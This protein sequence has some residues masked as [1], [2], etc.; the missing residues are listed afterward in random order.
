MKQLYFD[1]DIKYLFNGSKSFEL[2]QKVEGE[3]YREH[4]N[5]ITKKIIVNHKGY[6]IKLHGPVGWREIFKNLIQIKIPVIG[7]TRELKALKHLA[8]HGVN[9]LS[10]I[11][12]FKRGIIP[13]YSQSFL[14]TKE[15]KK[16]ISLEDFFMEGLHKKLLFKHKRF[17]LEKI[18]ETLRKIH[19]SGMN[20]RDLYLCHLHIEKDCNFNDLKIFVI[21]LHRAQI[22]KNVPE[23]WLVKDLGGFLHST[24]GFGLTER[25]Y[26]RFFKTYFNCSLE[27][28]SSKHIL[29]RI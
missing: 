27:S 6:F 9:T 4:A 5:R 13:A 24:M 1:E 2:A 23:R 16:T 7:A 17:L 21:D 28:L 22:R 20:H 10:V 15:L 12:Y 29:I 3:I 8:Y 26:Y 11:G 18:A 14:I 25:D 19:L